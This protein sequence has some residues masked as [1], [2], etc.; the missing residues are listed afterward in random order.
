MANVVSAFVRT[1]VLLEQNT[2]GFIRAHALSSG[3]V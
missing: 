1:K 2:G 3:R